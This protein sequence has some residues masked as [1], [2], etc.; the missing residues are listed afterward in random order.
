MA[1]VTQNSITIL[2]QTILHIIFL[3]IIRKVMAIS[4]EWTMI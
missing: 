4:T 3:S 2:N 1:L